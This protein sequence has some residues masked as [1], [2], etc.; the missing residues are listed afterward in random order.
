MPTFVGSNITESS[1]VIHNVYCIYMSVLK[2]SAVGEKVV[3]H[4][5]D[6][7]FAIFTFAEGHEVYDT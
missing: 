1:T 4:F 3:K 7:I 6:S 2:H 5:L